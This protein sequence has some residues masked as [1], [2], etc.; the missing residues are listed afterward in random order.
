MDQKAFTWR[1][2]LG[3]IIRDP[4]ERSRLAEAMGVNAITLTRW[5]STG[6]RSGTGAEK[7]GGEKLP[8]PQ[9]DSLRK[10]VA[11]LPD[12]RDKLIPSILQEFQEMTEEDFL[13]RTP[14]NI[15]EESASLSVNCYELV[16][17]AAAVLS[18]ELR[19]TTIFDHLFNY[20]LQ[21]LDP[22]RLG[23]LAAVVQCTKPLPGYK[24]RSLRELFRA[25]T[26]PWQREREER[27]VYRG[28][29]SLAGYAVTTCR[30]YKI[31]DLST[32]SG[33][34][35]GRRTQ[36]AVSIAA[37]PI[38][39]MG[40]VAGCLLFASTQPGY[41]T[42]ER[43]QLI[44]KYSH[45]ALTAFDEADHYNLQD[46]E[47]RLMPDEDAQEPFLRRFNKRIEEILVQGEITNW[48]QAAQVVMHQIENDLIALSS[49]QS[50][51]ESTKQEKGG[52]SALQRSGSSLLHLPIPKKS[53]R[54]ED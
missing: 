11:A 4:Q 15:T 46:I 40:R 22:E 35:P 25:G 18:G 51:S 23:L 45:L 26:P 44:Q 50:S 52:N 12:Y 36:D 21:Q 30:P 24:V 1:T 8:R 9:R 32:Y 42:R 49:A 37:C 13:P 47:L 38:Q 29:E 53:Q 17:E 3:E 48:G 19:F 5:V 34:L 27:N 33:W 16:L 31:E 10:L 43:M 39:Q 20:A 28:A 7:D 14:S 2:L 6:S 54:G 41:F